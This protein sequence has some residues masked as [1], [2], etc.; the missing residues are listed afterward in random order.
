MKPAPK[1]PAFGST[2][3]RI[4]QPTEPFRDVYAFLLR[5][6]WPIVVGLAAAAFLFVNLLFATLY[7][8]APGSI[9]NTQGGFLGAFYFSVQTFGAIGYGFMYSEGLW[10]NSIVVLESFVSLLF[11][12]VL[13]GIVFAKFARPRAMVLFS[14]NA[15]IEKRDGVRTLTF[16]VANERGNDVVEAAIRVAFMATHTS[17]EGKVL[18]RFHDLPL[19]RSESPLF[20]LSWQVFHPITEDSPL[21]GLTVDQMIEDD[22]RL[23]VTLT[24]FDGTFSQTIHARHMYWSD[25]LIDGHKFVDVIELNPDRSVTM[26]FRK[27]H[28]HEPE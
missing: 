5:T 14:K 16:R 25:D 6:R 19:A 18:R 4:G 27:F 12:A 20:V 28:G 1:R 13:T 22:M 9:A 21:Y 24:G 8:I 23:I 17:P 11:I 7:W 10:G 3:R 26:D 15:L 2:L